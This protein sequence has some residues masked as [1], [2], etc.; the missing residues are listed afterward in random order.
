MN[1]QPLA[2]PQPAEDA[3]NAPFLAGWRAGILKVQRCNDCSLTFFY[4]REMCPR[5][6]SQNLAWIDTKGLGHIASFS[7]VHRPVH[8]AFKNEPPVVMAE[9]LLPEGA[10]LLAR[11]L[12]DAAAVEI[13]KAVKV[14]SPDRARTYPLPTFELA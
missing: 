2:Y 12:A 13:G 1:D 7:V 4:P 14:V 8:D 3:I 9:V 6:W 11:V 10:S 5:C